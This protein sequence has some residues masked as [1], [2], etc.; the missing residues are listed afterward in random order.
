MMR[1]VY[2][3]SASMPGVI[4]RLKWEKRGNGALALVIPG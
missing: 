1:V 4:P 3:L 2:M